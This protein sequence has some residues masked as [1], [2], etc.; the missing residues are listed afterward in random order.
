[1]ATRARDYQHALGQ[2]VPTD[3]VMGGTLQRAGM[4][5]PAAMAA[6]EIAGRAAWLTWQIGVEDV[7]AREARQQLSGIADDIARWEGRF[8]SELSGQVTDAFKTAY[9]AAVDDDLPSLA[10]ATQ[11]IRVILEQYHNASLA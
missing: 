7:N 3:D 1:M 8:P 5:S 4:R 11:Q 9:A 10:H 2:D 6:I